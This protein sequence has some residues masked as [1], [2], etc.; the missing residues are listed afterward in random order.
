MSLV[1][2]LKTLAKIPQVFDVSIKREQKIINYLKSRNPKLK[3]DGIWNLYLINKDTPLICAHMDTV[4]DEKEAKLIES[5]HIKIIYM[6]VTRW[7][8]VNKITTIERV[9][10]SDYQIG[11][12]DKCW[13]AIAMQLYEEL[14]DKISLLFTVWEET[15]CVGSTYFKTN[16]KDLLEQCLYCVVPDRRN[17][18]DLLCQKHW[19]GSKEFETDVLE[20]L[21]PYW[22]TSEQGSICDANQFKSV[23]NCFNISV[24]YYEPH[25][26]KDWISL[27]EFEN[28]YNALHD[29]VSNYRERKE[30]YK[31]EIKPIKTW[32]GKNY[33]YD[34][35]YYQSWLFWW[36]HESESEFD[37]WNWVKVKSKWNKTSFWWIFTIDAKRMKMQVHQPL[38]FYSSDKSFILPK[39]TYD[40]FETAES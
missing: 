33:S 35:D 8:W 32:S 23:L 34:D 2:K 9:M 13:I 30:P 1:W 4:Q 17:W 18:W 24:W 11:W 29:L 6:D 20:Y 14:W 19:Y 3:Q 10:T 39:W 12:D 36:Y 25:T 40:W 21:S 37:E 26:S 5:N 31:F 15:W 38:M 16:H 7:W 27:D 28:T 22:F